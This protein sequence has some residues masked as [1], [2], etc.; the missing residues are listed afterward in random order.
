MKPNLIKRPP[1][2]WVESTLAPDKDIFQKTVRLR[3]GDGWETQGTFQIEKV[4]A[5]KMLIRVEFN[6]SRVP[7]R[8]VFDAIRV[9]QEQI[10]LWAKDAT[11]CVLKIPQQSSCL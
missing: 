10:D 7:G 5:T 6:S 2:S 11:S 9:S 8:I 3:A 4:N 1:E